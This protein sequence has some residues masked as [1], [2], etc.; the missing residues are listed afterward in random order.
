MLS[1]SVMVSVQAAFLVLPWPCQSTPVFSE[2]VPQ[3]AGTNTTSL[4]SPTQMT[5]VTFPHCLLLS[6]TENLALFPEASAIFFAT[7]TPQYHIIPGHHST[8]V[9]HAL[10]SLNDTPPLFLTPTSSDRPSLLQNK[11][12]TRS[13]SVEKGRLCTG[14]PL[15][16]TEGTPLG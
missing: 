9:T 13:S 12:L 11:V 1:N 4:Q 7:T 8:C 2:A 6:S 16:L 10:P 5:P 15:P 3:P 14:T